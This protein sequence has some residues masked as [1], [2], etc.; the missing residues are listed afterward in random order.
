MIL[1]LGVGLAVSGLL[2]AGVDTAWVRRY[3]GPA[4]DEDWA[5]CLAVDSLG[6]VYVAGTSMS[7][8]G[9][10]EHLDFVTI[11]YYP[12][13]DTAWVRRQDFGG[14]DI[15]Y[16]LGVDRQGNVYVAGTNNDS[17]MVTVK[18]GPTG[19][20]LWYGFFG[21]QGGACGLALDR[22]GNA[23][24][25]GYSLR[26]T[27]DGVTLK[28]RPDGDTAWARFLDWAGSEDYAI[29]SA[30][31]AQSDVV[32]T[33]EGYD[34][35]PGSDYVTVKYDSTGIQQWIGDY[36]GPVD[37]DMP[38]DV[39]TDTT[40]DVYVTGS[41]V[42]VASSEDYLT[43]R[44]SPDGETLWTRR[45]SGP[46]DGDDEARALVVDALGNVFVTGHAHFTSADDDCA[47]LKYTADGTL[48]WCARYNGPIG[49]GA[50]GEAL[51]VD[52]AGSV[53]V[54]GGG[55]AGS[56]AGGDCV[57]ICYTPAGET[58]WVKTYNGG[59][60]DR[61]AALCSDTDGNV[62]VA[63]RAGEY[64][65]L[66]MLVIKYVRSG[67][68]AEP[69]LDGSPQPMLSV[70]PSVCRTSTVIS[71]GIPAACEARLAVFTAAGRRVRTFTPASAGVGH[72]HVT[73]DGRNDR[74]LRV[75]PG[76]YT[77]VLEASEGTSRVKVVMLE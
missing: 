25:C 52:K 43:I 64:P 20:R 47:T 46:A 76:V 5:T 10:Y 31:G 13:G 17:R 70:R 30:T 63:G 56:Q 62:I 51:T 49:L 44:Y 26:A 29:A 12:D 19:N 68:A 21:T 48:A 73:W 14:K 39:A 22:Q 41:S 34:G 7:D 74:G 6:S 36:H 58:A 38:K 67:G 53:F 9:G 18:Y 45:Y 23:L 61:G 71:Y 4:H 27:M 11:K 77:V 42:G 50:G 72:G 37:W 32:V 55:W 1:L 35:S 69:R 3:D 28:Y 16:G 15:P 54:T 2:Q 57:T 65:Q 40:G 33:A 24:V 8:T 66:D 59:N 60:D 75:P